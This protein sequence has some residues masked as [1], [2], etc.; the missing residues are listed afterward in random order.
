MTIS[1][2]LNKEQETALTE[3]SKETNR[4]KSFYIKEA[5]ND[6]LENKAD[7]YLGVNRL[8]NSQGTM[9]LK[10]LRRELGL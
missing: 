7:Y 1:V 3:L 4:P 8:E 5:L 10:E 6:F 2:R 9:S